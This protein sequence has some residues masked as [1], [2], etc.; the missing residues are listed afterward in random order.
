M[1]RRIILILVFLITQLV[2]RGYSVFENTIHSGYYFTYLN[3]EDGL[4]NSKVNTIVRDQVGF[5]WFGTNEGINRYDGYNLWVYKHDPADSASLCDNLIRC[6]LA[7]NR[8]RV[9]IATENGLDVWDHVTET[10]HHVRTSN[11]SR[12]EGA[13]WKLMVFDNNHIMLAASSG[14][15]LVNTE[16]LVAKKVNKRFNI[17]ERTGVLS[18]FMDSFQNLYIG[19]LA[20][21]LFVHNFKSRVTTLFSSSTGNKKYLSGNRVECISQ[22]K[23]G[24]IWVGTHENG[25]NFFNRND[26]SFEWIDLDRNGNYQIRVRDIESDRFGR[27]W[28]GT[29]N[30]LY[31]KNDNSHSFILYAHK[32]EGISEILNSSIFDIYID[33]YD[34]M[35]LGT[36]SGGVNY[37]DF[38]QKRFKHIISRENDPRFLND[39]SVFAI[40]VDNQQN[41]WA[42]TERGGLNRFDNKTGLCSYISAESHSALYRDNNIKALCFDEEDNLWIGTY[43]DGLNC[44][45]INSNTFSNYRH[46]PQSQ[47]SLINNTIYSIV[48]DKEK[49]L[50]IGTFEG[51][52]RLPYKSTRFISYNKPSDA[53]SGLGKSRIFTIYAD[54][55]GNIWAG[56]KQKGLYLYNKQKDLFIRYKNS[57]DDV[58]VTSVFIDR[59]GHIWTGSTDG[60]RCYNPADD[61]LVHYTEKN[62][63]PTSNISSIIAD[64][65]DNLWISTANGLVKF[66]NGVVSP[67]IIDFKVYNTFKGLKLLQYA[68]NSVSKSISG[69]LFFG[70]FNGF[71]SFNPDEIED[72]PYVPDV[73]II[74]LKIANSNIYPEQKVNKHTIHRQPIYLSQNITLSHR[75]YIV[76]FEFSTMHYGQPEAKSFAYMLEGF[77]EDWNYT[78]SDNRF[79]TYTNL[80][81][82]DYVLKVKAANSDN[83]WGKTPAV[84]AVKVV[85]PVWKTWWFRLLLFAVA[86]VI[87]LL[88]YRLRLFSIRQQ[89][90]ILEK[91]VMERTKEFSEVNSLLEQK[92]EEIVIQ[93]EELGRHRFNLEQLVKERTS[94]LEKARRKAE[95][96]DRLKS[97]FLANMSHEI[98]TPMNAIVGFS[99]LLL[100]E[101]DEEEKKEYVKIITNNS[102]NLIVLINDILDISMI[103][104]DQLHMNAQH[105]NANLLLQELANTYRLKKK[106]GIEIILDSFPVSR[107]ILFTDQFRFRQILNNLLGNALKYTE[108][109]FIRFG[110]N[111]T[112]DFARFYV[113]DTGV[114][115]DKKDYEKVFNYFQKLDNRDAKLYRGAGIGLSICKKL[116]DLMGGKIWLESKS[117]HGT[118]FYF[119]LPYDSLS[120]VAHE[121]Q[122]GGKDAIIAA[123]FSDHQVI[124]AEDEPENYALLEKILKPLKVNI[125]WKHNGKEILEYVQKNTVLKNTV[126]L[127]DIKMPV[128]NGIQAFKEI[129]K[130]NKTIPV[131]AVTAYATENERNA[132]IDQGFDFYMSKPFNHDH[133]VN[134]VRECLMKSTGD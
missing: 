45:N 58:M 68:N 27:L 17:P 77:D 35:W 119:T 110:Y 112:D 1:T 78:T 41:I 67:E 16:S 48:T 75:H 106:P 130:I 4:S 73:K 32:K 21:G 87:I 55:Q 12:L 37:C 134:T 3:M 115:I 26:S 29:Y 129:R 39:L 109:G 6:L 74:G 108:Q 124:I 61:W 91:M 30:G 82:K 43:Q 33:P 69:E 11:N 104:A 133:I 120:G 52:C 7:D 128:M 86:F 53:Y 13:T 123:D 57:F 127:M 85:P 99:N 88:F 80:P 23:D 46:N 14:L 94:E 44:Y 64:D 47:Y 79:A 118:T 40:A 22:D 49:N 122:S 126:I 89:K 84:L 54:P 2:F 125:L 65:K 97:A 92:Q 131:I 98:R 103:E 114:G 113:S 56:S 10:F 105:F 101:P 19:S 5:M 70:G 59:N 100:S 9:W 31:L 8:K 15:Y 72:Y 50:W 93:N 71:I 62:G 51:I 83:I 24:N 76:T 38:N 63:L 28:V 81:G 117:G 25:L 90:V 107:L 60:L 36:Y 132:I 18:L 116:L 102:E 34:V 111:V 95:E 96:S 121:R 20:E 66:V 42:G